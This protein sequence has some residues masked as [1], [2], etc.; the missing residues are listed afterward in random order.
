MVFCTTPIL[1][2]IHS[3]PFLSPATPSLLLIPYYNPS[4]PLLRFPFHGRRV[5]GKEDLGRKGDRGDNKHGGRP[6]I[7]M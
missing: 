7:C 3:E 1:R 2:N 6:S 5:K 4:V